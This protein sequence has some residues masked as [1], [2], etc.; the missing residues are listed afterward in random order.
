MSNNNNNN[1]RRPDKL[2]FFHDPINMFV[3]VMYNGIPS[4]VH[5]PIFSDLVIDL[6]VRFLL[7]LFHYFKKCRSKTLK[8]KN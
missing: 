2:N 7:R 1:K 6:F 4:S 8:N 3:Y 5:H